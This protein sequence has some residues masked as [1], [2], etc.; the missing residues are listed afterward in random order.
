[1][2]S[3][4][5][6]QLAVYSDNPAHL[7]NREKFQRETS[8]CM[9][10]IMTASPMIWVVKY[11]TRGVSS[12]LLSSGKANTAMKTI[13]VFVINSRTPRRSH[14]ALERRRRGSPER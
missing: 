1:M 4:K 10:N 12:S 14:L 9:P 8:V 2:P 5:A 7:L 6:M 13:A 3:M 11:P